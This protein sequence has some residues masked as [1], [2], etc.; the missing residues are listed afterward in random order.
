MAVPKNILVATDFS[1]YSDMA[2]NEAI[3]LAGQDSTN[4][5]LLHVIDH[6]HNQKKDGMD[7]GKEDILMELEKR[8]YKESQEM[9]DKQLDSLE[10]GKRSRIMASIKTGPPADVILKEQK[11]NE[12]DLIVIGSHGVKGFLSGLV[13]GVTYRVVKNAPCSVMVV[14][15]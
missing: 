15:Q 2:L 13:G 5:H 6:V 4:I 10:S 9:M 12:A 14:R 7:I 1:E 3:K 8:Y 11:R